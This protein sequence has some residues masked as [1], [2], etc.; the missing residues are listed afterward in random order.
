M[1]ASMIAHIVDTTT[2]DLKLPQMT[3]NDIE[4]PQTTSAAKIKMEGGS[5][6]EIGETYSDYLDIIILKKTYKRN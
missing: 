6:H 4:R 1:Q 5:L 3:S 2:K